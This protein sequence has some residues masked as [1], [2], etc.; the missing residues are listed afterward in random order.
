MDRGDVSCTNED[1]LAW[2]QRVVSAATRGGRTVGTAESC[3]GGLV[4]GALTAI[5]GSS[6]AV[7]GG[8]VSYAISVKHEVLGVEG[9]VLDEPS[10]GAVSR[11]CAEQMAAGARRVLRADVAIATT[12]IAGPG[13]AEP[14]KP[15]GTVWFGVASSRGERSERHVFS[16]DRGTV[17]R[18]AVYVALGLLCDELLK[19]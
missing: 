8:I 13:G 7:R 11:E 5:P 12:G 3:T 19:S 14:G 16:G 10:I 17:R 18:K 1:V 15:V 4:S 9:A 2:A 6:L